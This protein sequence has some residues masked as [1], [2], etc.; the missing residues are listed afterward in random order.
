MPLFQ[1]NSNLYIIISFIVFMSGINLYNFG[2]VIEAG[3]SGSPISIIIGLI[4]TISSIVFIIWKI[5]IKY[6][7]IEINCI[8][9]SF[10]CFIF[11]LWAYSSNHYLHTL[12]DAAINV[13]AAADAAGI[14]NLSPLDPERIQQ[15][16]ELN[17]YVMIAFIIIGC[18]LIGYF[19]YKWRKGSRMST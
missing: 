18:V 12:Y 4:L 19:I 16:T 17:N 9:A 2:I 6:K 5:S 8:Y 10:F 11:S 15:M 14:G 3:F 1:R 13:N 7:Q